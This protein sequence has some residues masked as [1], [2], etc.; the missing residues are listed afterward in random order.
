V[1]STGRQFTDGALFDRAWDY[2]FGPGYIVWRIDADQN[3]LDA[4]ITHQFTKRFSME[5]ALG[6]L[7]ASGSSGNDY[8]NTYATLSGA[9]GF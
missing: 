8:D 6:Y 1:A 3:I 2:A 7:D 4:G 9:F 5:F